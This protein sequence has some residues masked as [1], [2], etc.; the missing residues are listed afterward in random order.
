MPLQDCVTKNAQLLY[1]REY[2]RHNRRNTNTV[3]IV[4]A[5]KAAQTHGGA[6]SAAAYALSQPIGSRSISNLCVNGGRCQYDTS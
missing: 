2:E 5:S 6:H 1:E 3:N 4:H